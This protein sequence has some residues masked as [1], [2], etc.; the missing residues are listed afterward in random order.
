METKSKG[1]IG[2][3]LLGS[4]HIYFTILFLILPF[5]EDKRDMADPT[6][7]WYIHDFFPSEDFAAQVF[8]SIGITIASICMVFIGISLR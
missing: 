6:R 4:F 7:G 2:F 1:I 3:I 5:V 8:I